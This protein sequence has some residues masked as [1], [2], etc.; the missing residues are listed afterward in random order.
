MCRPVVTYSCD[1][2][3]FLEIQS[4]RHPC[5]LQTFSGDDFIPNDMLISEEE[6]R[7]CVVVTGPNMG[8]KSTLM[9][10]TGLIVILAHLVSFFHFLF[11]C[12]KC[13]M[14]NRVVMFLPLA[15]E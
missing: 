2:Q 9:R 11:L 13:F 12:L 1:G 15:V 14:V 8:G 7:R 5:V 10:Q 3:P 4:G 6:D